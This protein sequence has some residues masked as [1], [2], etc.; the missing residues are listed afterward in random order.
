MLTDAEVQRIL[1]IA[2]HPDDIDFSAA[3]T[4]ARWTDAG[5]K[6][7]YCLV[8]DGDAGGYDESMPRSEMGPTAAQ[9]TNRGRLLRGRAGSSFPRLPGRAGGAALALRKDLARVIR[10]SGRTGW[11]ARHPTVITRR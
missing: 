11:P 8:T 10:R 4:I 3:G 5:I 9:G 6:V 2:A 7:T 1:V